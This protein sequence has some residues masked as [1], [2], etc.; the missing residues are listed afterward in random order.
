MA[1]D[2]H[3][4]TARARAT[5]WGGILLGLLLLIT[6]F[7]RG[8]GLWA[9]SGTHADENPWMTRTGNQIVIPAGSPLRERL[10]VAAVTASET[11]LDLQLPGVVES[12]PALT[13]P[14]LTPASGR[15]VDLKVALGDR[16]I[17]GQVLVTLDCADLAQAYDDDSKAASTLALSR[18]NLARQE[19]Q[20]KI[21]AA[22]E[23]DLDQSR[24]DYQQAVAEYARTQARLKV[25]GAS[26]DPQSRSHILAVR[27]PVSGSVTTLS[28]A[29][30]N[31]VNDVTQPLMTVADLRSVWV[32]ALV[33]EKDVAAVSKDQEAQVTLDAYPGQVR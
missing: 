22:A 6:L 5:L 7:T 32:T 19:G 27:A 11:S 4:P 21:G 24:S 18:K 29:R 3:T 12:D 16:V 25:L 26:D 14:V 28:V 2:I 23:R 15:V 31:M 30:G 1:M 17:A 10:L 13:A 33:A 8:F 20:A 9:G